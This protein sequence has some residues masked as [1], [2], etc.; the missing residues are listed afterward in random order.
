MT[1]I[2]LGLEVLTVLAVGQAPVWILISAIWLV[3]EGL[4]ADNVIHGGH[5]FQMRVGWF[6]GLG[7]IFES[8]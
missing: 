1:Y 3:L 8:S 7:F 2:L 5:T 4:E 6:F